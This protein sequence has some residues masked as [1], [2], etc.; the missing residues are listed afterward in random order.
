MRCE[1]EGD[2]EKVIQNHPIAHDQQEF[3]ARGSPWWTNAGEGDWIN[4]VRHLSNCGPKPIQVFGYVGDDE[5]FSEEF[6]IDATCAEELCTFQ[7]PDYSVPRE[8][9]TCLSS[10]D[11]CQ[12]DFTYKFV[13]DFCVKEW[14]YHDFQCPEGKG[15]ILGRDCYTGPQDCKFP[16]RSALSQ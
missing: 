2:V 16:S 6:L 9:H 1:T 13:N 8:D 15:R 7:C 14:C 4:A 11:N 10:F 12:C 5:C 3:I